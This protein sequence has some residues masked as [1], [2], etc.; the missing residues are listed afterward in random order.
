MSSYGQLCS[1]SWRHEAGTADYRAE[2]LSDTFVERVTW[3]EARAWKPQIGYGEITIDVGPGCISVRFWIPNPGQ[4][5]EKH[6][7]PKGNVLGYLAPVTMPWEKVGTQ[8]E[9][10]LLGLAL[11]IEP[12]G[13]VTVVGEAEF[14]RWAQSD[15]VSPVAVEHAEMRVR[16]LTTL[17]AQHRFPPP[18]VR[19]FAIVTE[20]QA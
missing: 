12:S 16:E 10:H 2:W 11:W 17:T 20:D 5:V 8:L 19:N 1:G 14:D 3:L 15:E 13:R 18:L 9:A 7:D 6:L 4:I